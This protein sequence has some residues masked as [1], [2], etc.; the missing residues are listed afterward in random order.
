[1]IIYNEERPHQSLGNLP[2]TFC[3]TPRQRCPCF[4]RDA[5]ETAY[6]R[7]RASAKISKSPPFDPKT[8]SADNPSVS[9]TEP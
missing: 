5:Q 1:M 4:E 7:D 3:A 2:P 9:L 8:I 6:Q